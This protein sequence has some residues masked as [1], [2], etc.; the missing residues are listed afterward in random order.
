MECI[1]IM[2][3]DLSV[4]HQAVNATIICLASSTKVILLLSFIV[5]E[6]HTGT[7]LSSLPDMVE[8][9]DHQSALPA[10]V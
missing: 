5:W 3:F 7:V 4:F 8:Q 1:I 9:F 10:K 2:F 6:S